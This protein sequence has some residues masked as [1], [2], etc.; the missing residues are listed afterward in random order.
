MYMCNEL[1][2]ATTGKKVG[3]C[4]SLCKSDLTRCLPMPVCGN[5]DCESASK[6]GNFNS[7]GIVE[8]NANCPEDCP[9]LYPSNGLKKWE[10]EAPPPD[11]P[12]CGNGTCEW[13]EAD[14]SSDSRCTG[15]GEQMR[16][17]SGV[18]RLGS[19]PEDCREDVRRTPPPHKPVCGDGRCDARGG[20]S[21]RTCPKDCGEP[22]FCYQGTGVAEQLGSC[23]QT[24]KMACGQ[25]LR[26]GFGIWFGSYEAECMRFVRFEKGR[27][28]V[29]EEGIRTCPLRPCFA[30]S[31]NENC[32]LVRGSKIDRNG[33]LECPV[34]E[35]PRPPPSPC[36]NGRLDA[37]ANEIGRL[38]DCDDGNTVNGDGCSGLP[39]CFGDMCVSAC[40]I[41]PGWLCTGS[42]SRCTR[43][44]NG[45]PERAC[46]PFEIRCG[47][48][49]DGKDR[50][51]PVAID[52]CADGSVIYMRCDRSRFHG[53]AQACK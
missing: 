6:F 42:P 50:G 20:E 8:N 12:I 46:W 22:G 13:G 15:V 52:T 1:C 10:D 47:T 23:V 33:C 40:S 51:T 14:A 45:R 41:E 11:R 4:V 26:D 19:C 53:T 9:P 29:K 25:S 30:P 44:C 35:C 49:K 16:C 31:E 43:A 27:N 48:F 17:P 38:E 32:T 34:F 2:Q 7:S 5:N 28:T 18:L 24:T 37:N 36:G 21:S 3:A 39:E